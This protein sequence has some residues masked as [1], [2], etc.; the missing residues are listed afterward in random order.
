MRLDDLKL[1][2]EQTEA[3]DDEAETH[4]RQRRADPGQERPLGGQIV[5]GVG[6]QLDLVPHILMA[7]SSRRPPG[8]RRET[9]VRS[10]GC[11]VTSSIRRPAVSSIA[12]LCS[13]SL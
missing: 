9:R 11:R 5:A 13:S 12:Q 7:T 2:Q 8:D 3:R 1:S 6:L 4:E 10:S